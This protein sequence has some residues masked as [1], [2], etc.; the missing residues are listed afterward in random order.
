MISKSFL[1]VLAAVVLPIGAMAGDDINYTFLDMMYADNGI[2]ESYTETDV[3]ESVTLDV[4]GGGGFAVLGSL[5]L[6]ENWHVFADFAETDV[7]L[8]IS[9][10]VDDLQDSLSMGGDVQDWRVGF[11]FN[12]A[13]GKNL[14]GVVQVA[15]EDRKVDFGNLSL[16]GDT[17]RLELDDDGFGAMVGLRSNVTE[18]FELNGHVRYSQIL[19]LNLA[20]D[21]DDDVLDN[22]V[23][24]GAGGIYHVTDMFSFGADV[25]IGDSTAWH[26]F[27][28][29]G[30]DR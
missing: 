5:A 29:F 3:G 26:A 25:E 14:D 2:D 20:A 13:L 28:R 22:D 21:A 18:K 17:T 10:T 1:S 6:H 15:W 12:A 11:G 16:F 30:F 19:G 27:A 8:K 23:L 9:V 7:D 4:D 24:Y